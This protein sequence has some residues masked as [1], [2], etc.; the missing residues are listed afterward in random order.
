M[1]RRRRSYQTTLAGTAVLSGL[2]VHSGEPV[3]LTV[4][5]A[6]TNTGIAFLRTGIPDSDDLEISARWD[7]VAAT[8]LCTVIGVP[9]R[10][11]VSTIEHLMAALYG[12][13]VD[14][15]I[16]ELDAPEVPVMDGSSSAFVDLVDHVG[17]VE[18]SAPSRFIRVKKSV[19]VEHGDSVGELHPFDGFKCDITIDFETPLIG[20]QS[21]EYAITADIFRDQLSRARTFGAV[22]DVEKLWA[23]G[24]A[25]G[26]SLENSVALTEEGI[27][28]PEGLRWPDEFVRHKALDAVGD[29]ALAGL[30]MLGAYHSFKGGHRL[31]HSVLKALFADDDAWE[32]VDGVPARETGHAEIG[33]A[34]PAYGPQTS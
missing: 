32:I 27:L 31:N 19:R 2:G 12:L 15:A 14:N 8:E 25:L 7:S 3:T 4:H 21:F 28:N 26:S 13:G 1:G 33:M 5:P 6:D 24:F 34:A 9:G 22:K 17:I 29:L 11:S 10:G 23:M 20:R 16:I 30:P 18:Q